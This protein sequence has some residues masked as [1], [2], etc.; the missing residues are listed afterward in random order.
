MRV[1]ILVDDPAAAR[2]APLCSWLEQIDGLEV[3]L[4]PDARWACRIAPVDVLV[5]LVDEQPLPEAVEQAVTAHLGRGGG[6]VLLGHTLHAW[7]DASFITG[8]VGKPGQRQPRTE[9]VVELAPHPALRRLEPTL[10]LTDDAW[11]DA[12]IPADADPWLRTTWHFQDQMLGWSC[13]RAVVVT[14]GNSPQTCADERFARVVLRAVRHAAGLAEPAPLRVGMLGYGAIGAEH[15]SAIATVDG[16]DLAAVCD[17]D[18]GRLEQAAQ[19]FPEARLID[20][21]AGLEADDGIDIVLVSVPPNRHTEAATAMLRAGKH[22]VVEKPFA[23]TVAEADAVIGA[24]AESGRA[25]TVYQNRRWDPDF[26]AVLACVRSGRI[27][28][29]FHVE[30]FVG[31][32]AHPCRYWHSHEPV[33]GGVIYDWGSHY[34]DWILQI[35]DTPVAAVSGARHKRVWR[36]VTNADMAR[37]T[38]RFTGGE[39]AEFIHS[40]IAAAPK[41][42]WYVLGTRGAITA[43]WR[44]ERTIARGVSGELVATPLALTDA[45][46]DVRVH[47]PDG[48]RRAH[49]EALVLPPRI[50]APFHRNLADHLL[51]GEPLA[52]T[53]AQARR[54]TAVL[55]A[56][57]RSAR[58]DGRL[59][60]W[61]R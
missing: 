9:L 60:R 42:K 49:V 29:V 37:V 58:E 1:V 38:I 13:A 28:E 17:R 15:A 45:Q 5:A 32:F 25:L 40:D 43:E 19:A 22:V 18:R 31:G 52:V 39:E 16:L 44:E 34:L 55:E 35:V 53:P 50:E 20:G 61:G 24:A 6:L 4:V 11:L 36:D 47:I 2:V 33:S 14:L 59:V 48:T 23:L 41:P 10:V 26:R 7:R 8:I 51:T 21:A 54:T 3:E 56:A 27:G 12:G 46:A 57:S 30:A